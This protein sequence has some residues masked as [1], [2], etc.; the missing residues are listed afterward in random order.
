[1]KSL[2]SSSTGKIF[3]YRD[4]PDVERIPMRKDILR[5]I[6]EKLTKYYG[7]PIDALSWFIVLY[8]QDETKVRYTFRDIEAILKQLNIVHI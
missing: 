2:K 8:F 4:L 1:M 5:Q 3:K 7:T 6:S